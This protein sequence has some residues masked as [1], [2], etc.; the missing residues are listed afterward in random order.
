MIDTA[1][2]ENLKSQLDTQGS[3][4]YSANAR[5]LTTVTAV[6]IPYIQHTPAQVA[7]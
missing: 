7:L 3:F 6:A 2:L 4:T 5:T 1:S